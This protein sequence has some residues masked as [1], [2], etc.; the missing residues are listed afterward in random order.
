MQGRRSPFTW[1]A[2]LSVRTKIAL[3]VSGLFIA[4]VTGVGLLSLSYFRARFEDTIYEQQFTLVTTLA[5]SIDARLRIAEQAIAGAAADLPPDFLADADKTQAFL[6]RQGVLHSIFDNGIF[7]LTRDGTFFVESPDRGARGRQIPPDNWVFS[8]AQTANRPYVTNAY[9][10]PRAG[11]P[12]VSIG[13][14]LFDH[15]GGIVM[16]LHGGLKLLGE[17][18]LAELSKT[19]LGHAGYLFLVQR[20]GTIIMHPDPTHIMKS[21]AE[22]GRNPL[23][24]QALAGFEGSG[25]TVTT[26]GVKTFASFKRLRE[27]GWILGASFPESEVYA[28][29]NRAT[30]AFGLLIGLGTA[31]VLLTVWLLM[32]HLTGPLSRVTAHVAA[33]P[34]KSGPARFLRLRA[35]DEIG[36]LGTAVDHMVAQLEANELALRELNATLE[37]RVRERTAEL[38]AANLTGAHT[39]DLLSRADTRLRDALEA[40]PEGVALYDDAMRLVMWNQQALELIVPAHRARLAVGLPMEEVLLLFRNIIVPPGSA[41]D[42]ASAALVRER[43][44]VLTTSPEQADTEIVSW[45]G[46]AI[47]VKAART[48]DGGLVTVQH[49]VTD[50]RRA[51][52][53]LHDAIAHLDSGIWLADR[54]GRVRLW[55][56]KIL[57]MYPFLSGI[58]EEGVPMQRLSAAFEAAGY[59]GP[60]W[61]ATDASQAVRTD[62]HRTPDDRTF[63]VR[64]VPIAEGGRLVVSTDVTEIEAAQENLARS[65]RMS[66][67]GALVAG[68][69]HEI[70]TPIGIGVTAASHIEESTQ[71]IDRGY[72]AGRL[73]QADLEAF[74]ADMA[75][76]SRLLLRNL[77]RA[78]ELVASFK[79]VS[80]DQS[81][82]DRRAVDLGRLLSDIVTTLGPQLR[83]SRNK[84][85]LDCPPGVVMDCYPGTLSQVVTNLVM[86]SLFHAFPDG[87]PGQMALTV[88]PDVGKVRILYRDD[89]VGVA[90]DILKRIFE[91]FFTTKRGQGGSG[92]GLSVVYNLVTH[93]LGGTIEASSPPGAGLSFRI[94]LPV[95]ERQA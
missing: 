15:E 13:I 36:R 16:R 62:R 7:L 19:G 87:R 58:L 68:V 84:L 81:I 37:D 10:S 22:L 33:L 12:G 23:L 2:A 46:R 49:D 41:P 91:P 92:L 3:A 34:G 4:F 35:Q 75:E 29:F 48:R 8:P 51:Q 79:R 52:Q 70:N 20:D 24:E 73:M 71:S 45:D 11:G 32:R 39:R 66:A 47:R 54:D 95:S 88:E 14:P 1:Y 31:G 65:E 86:N 26:A 83:R 5:E 25:H 76:T 30:R 72:R 80:V 56:P 89:G 57:E 9:L 42:A 77:E 27:S 90:P 60:A 44:A 59:R 67:L 18:L 69:A 38:E 50:V 85:S 6:D 78:A 94:T 64:E 53:R 28:P 63:L 55:N 17:N 82:D 21:L 61:I 43:M 93:R 40:M 74:I